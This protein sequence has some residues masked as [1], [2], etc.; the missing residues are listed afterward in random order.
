MIFKLKDPKDWEAFCKILSLYMDGVFSLK[1]FF[2]LFDEKFKS[3]FKPEVKEE[4]DKLLQSRDTTRR[5]NCKMLKSWN[6]VEGFNLER[7]PSQCYYK[8]TAEFPN[9]IAT[10]KMTDPIYYLNINDKYIS[11]STGSENS[12]CRNTNVVNIFKVEDKL[13]EFDMQIDN[14][15]RSLEILDGEI[16]KF[17]CLSESEQAVFTL[18]QNKFEPMRYL[19]DKKWKTKIID[20]YMTEEKP[21]TAKDLQK[22]KETFKERLEFHKNLKKQSLGELKDILKKNFTKSLDHKSFQYKD[23][24]KKFMNKQQQVK[25][26]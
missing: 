18:S 22:I 16:S 11:V 13:F 25:A 10:K 12:N 19:W 6:D 3:K 21:I 7:V 14:M 8:L 9:P 4:L 2:I 24:L 20:E 26:I 1:Q 15:S 17:N 5:T 23:F